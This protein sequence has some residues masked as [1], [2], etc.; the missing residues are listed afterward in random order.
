MLLL[1]VVAL[2]AVGGAALLLRRGEERFE[3]TG[4]VEVRGGDE[5]DDFDLPEVL[6]S[7]AGGS[8]PGVVET[9]IG[10]GF[11]LRSLSD[12]R[13]EAEEVVLGGV[14]AVEAAVVA[15]S[16]G[17]RRSAAAALDEAEGAVAEAQ[18]ALD[19]LVDK[20]GLD[21]PE[22]AL[23]E[24]VD[25]LAQLREERDGLPAGDPVGRSDLDLRIAEAQ[26][27]QFDLELAVG[28][29]DDLAGTLDAAEAAQ[30]EAEADQQQ[31]ALPVVDAEIDTRRFRV[32]PP[33]GQR[34]VGG[35]VLGLAV[36]SLLGVLR[37]SV[38][39]RR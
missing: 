10:G 9:G 20:S 33:V 38:R 15:A 28:R 23:D 31:L 1:A 5:L 6:G 11:V 37:G 18:A 35:A 2:L 21:D 32:D 29:Y 26:Q 13:A 19:E 27:E 4:V 30:A 22:A 24:V 25:E 12:S 17:P 7:T 3:V 36:L 16:A 34:L 8:G 39:R 14:A